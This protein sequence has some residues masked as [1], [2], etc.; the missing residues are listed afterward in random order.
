MELDQIRRMRVIDNMKRVEKERLRKA[1][2]T[3]VSTQDMHAETMRDRLEIHL[4]NEKS[5]LR[6]HE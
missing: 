3:L 4:S 1:H 6:N 5:E 2:Q